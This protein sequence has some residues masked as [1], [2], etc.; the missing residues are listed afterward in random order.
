MAT[1]SVNLRL[2]QGDTLTP[3]KSRPQRWR[4]ILHIAWPLIIANSFWNLQITIDRI[5]LGHFSTEA[6]GAATAG[7]R[8]L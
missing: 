1:A 2:L 5:Y 8:W 3:Q 4:E 6:L 7:K